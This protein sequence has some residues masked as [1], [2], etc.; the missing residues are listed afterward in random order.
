MIDSEP[1]VAAGSVPDPA[2]TVGSRPARIPWTDSAWATAAA[3]GTYFCMYAFRKPFTAAEFEGSEVAGID[4]KT[5]LVT[6]QV[7]GY[8]LSKFVGIRIVSEMPSRLRPV[9]IVLLILAAEVAL[10]LAGATPRPWN[11]VWLFCNGLPLGMVFGLVL[12]CLEG[13][14]VSEVLTAGL[15]ASFIVAD[16][17]MKSVGAWLLACGVS[18]D[19]M[20][21]AAGA[22]FLAPLAVCA[23][24]LA[25]VPAP[26]E[27]DRQARAERG[28]LSRVERRD[29]WSRH[30]VGLS[31]IVVLYL[32]V[33]ILR[34][35]RADFAP[36]LWHSLGVTA[37]P[38]T[39]TRSELVVAAGVIAINGTLAAVRDNRTA[40]FVA[41]MVCGA[42]IA[43]AVGALVSQAI[44][45]L[46]P[47][48]FMILIGLGLYMPYVAVH[49]TVFERL[50]AMTRE[51]GTVAFLMYVADAFGYLGYV[52][53]M[54][55]R[56]LRGGQPAT[57][58]DFLAFF[59]VVAW[60]TMLVSAVML[61]IAVRAFV[62]V[63]HGAPAEA[64]ARGAPAEERR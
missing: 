26:D 57:G 16:G 54:L 33:T 5:V 18:E 42:G 38:G 8:T 23:S 52:G 55:G 31:A 12:G 64:R 59:G 6:A 46:A 3:F 45:V 47:L 60:S 27:H 61:V 36:E 15:C 25:R 1:E 21:A 51:R 2:G 43:V 35:V 19:W 11:A 37:A 56:N 39:F 40:F 58:S 20:P 44:G 34:S 28:T 9:A 29:L 13:R 48:P 7:I 14:R 63:E 24:M 17:A 30:A 53:V 50:L 32:L 49:T 41:L 22:M 62:R 4:F 10:V